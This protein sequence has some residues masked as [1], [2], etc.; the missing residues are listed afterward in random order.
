MQSRLYKCKT[1]HFRQGEKEHKFSFSYFVWLL[2][3]DELQDV[4]KRIALFSSSRWNFFHFNASDYMRWSHESV[5]ESISVYLKNRG[6]EEEVQNIQLLTTIKT[7]GYGFNPVV[8]YFCTT[9]TGNRYC[10]A[11]VTNTFGEKKPYLLGPLTDT[12]D[13]KFSGEAAKQFY[14]SPFIDESAKLKLRVAPI[15]EELDIHI[16]SLE[17]DAPTLTATLTGT[18][19]PLTNWNLLKLVARTP[20]VPLQI[21]VGIHWH[22]LRLFLKGIPFFSKNKKFNYLKEFENESA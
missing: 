14:I 18:P 16:Q 20:L 12:S 7:A 9:S 5:K 4:E 2:D 15:E 22:A 11:E 10:L 6:I 21:I 17:N 1:T 3:L 8:F 19:V 13:T